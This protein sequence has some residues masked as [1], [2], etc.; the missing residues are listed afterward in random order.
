LEWPGSDPLQSI[1]LR[2]RC[3]SA[4]ASSRPLRVGWHST[5]QA[6]DRLRTRPS[7]CLP[8]TWR[9]EAAWRLLRALF[10]LP[11]LAT[12]TLRFH[13]ST[14]VC[15]TCRSSRRRSCLDLSLEDVTTTRVPVTC[16]LFSSESPK[17]SGLEPAYLC[18]NSSHGVVNCSPLRRHSPCASTPGQPHASSRYFPEGKHRTESR[19]VA[20]LRPELAR[21]QTRS[22]LAVPPGFSGFLRASL[23]RFVAPCSRPWGSPGCGHH[24]LECCSFAAWYGSRRP[25]SVRRRC[26]VLLAKHHRARPKPTA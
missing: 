22:A 7:G 12:G 20:A 10:D 15:R 25:H 19:C 2:V 23:C 24:S 6:M 14:P 17:W 1:S 3:D 9:C 16:G 8:S 18:R 4:S 26:V 11:C 13:L 5:S 21:A